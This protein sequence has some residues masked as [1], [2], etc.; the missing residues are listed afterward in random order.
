MNAKELADKIKKRGLAGTLKMAAVKFKKAEYNLSPP[1]SLS[2][3]RILEHIFET[4]YKRVIIFENHF[5]YRNIMMQRPQHMLRSMGDEDNLIFYNSYYD[6]DYVRGSRITRIRDSVYVLDLFYYRKYLR[7]LCGAVPGKYVMVYSTDT[8]PEKRIRE[9]TDLG[10]QVI[11][12]YVDDI[13]PDLISPS[14]IRKIM[15]RHRKLLSQKTTLAVATADKLYQNALK[16]CG[17]A[18][19]VHISNGA[20]CGKFRPETKTEDREY[21]DWLRPDKI[22]VGYYG[23]LASWVDYSLLEYLVKDGDIQLILI[24]IEHDGSLR[25]SGLL[26]NEN[27]KYFGRKQYDL[28]AGYVYY[29]DVCIIPFVV[30][31]ITRATSPVK[32]FEYMSMEKQVVTTALPECMKYNAVNIADTKEEFAAMVRN[33][34][35]HRS[36]PDRKECLKKCAA[37]NDWAAKAGELKRCLTERERNER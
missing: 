4:E 35:E 22:H 33:C 29:F 18:Q 7:E 36:D 2:R 24:G 28:L 3:K 31:E 21:L 9:Y 15:D 23:A 34:W 5:G 14:R 16:L 20:E 10:F 26:R 8:V 17:G 12:E 1:I 25:E 13:N 19:V 11:Y 30:N 27:V 32:L 37:E 6:I